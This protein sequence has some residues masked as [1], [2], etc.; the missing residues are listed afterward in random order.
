MRALK[1]KGAFER[2]LRCGLLELL[3]FLYFRFLRRLLR[4]SHAVRLLW[5]FENLRFRHL[6]FRFPPLPPSNKPR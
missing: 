5:F 6:N 3:T 1:N 4:L 2:H